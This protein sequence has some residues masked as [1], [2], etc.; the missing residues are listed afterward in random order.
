MHIQFIE[1]KH[2]GKD[3]KND[4]E[5][6]D[7]FELSGEGW[8]QGFMINTVNYPYIVQALFHTVNQMQ[9]QRNPWTTIL[10]Y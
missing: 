5:T 4:K 3:K 2:G 7:P 8:W 10:Y 9:L 6:K 1:K